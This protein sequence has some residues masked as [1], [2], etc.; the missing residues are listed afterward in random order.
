LTIFTKLIEAG[1]MI[2]DKLDEHFLPVA[3][4]PNS[5]SSC[6]RCELDN[7]NEQIYYVTTQD[8]GVYVTTNQ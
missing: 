6:T 3:G 4:Y 5:N 1:A 2:L 7:E 8:I